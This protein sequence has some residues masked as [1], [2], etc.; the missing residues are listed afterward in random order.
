MAWF[1]K[2]GL[3]T[4]K[5]ITVGH[6]WSDDDGIQ[7]PPNWMSWSNTYKKK[8]K[9]EEYIPTP[10]KTYN[11]DFY[12]LD[13]TPQDLATLKSSKI[14]SLKSMVGGMLSGSDWYVIRKTER[15]VAIPSNIATYRAALHTELAK[16]EKAIT[17]AKDLAAF[18]KLHDDDTLT[19]W[20]VLGS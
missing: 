10:P 5:Q 9:V 11:L 16:K 2:K 18:I 4:E 7:H 17:D 15:S 6:P 1:Y 3:G 13:G 8:M 12:N 20:P 14:S 19:S